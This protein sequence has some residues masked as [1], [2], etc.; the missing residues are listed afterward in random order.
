VFTSPGSGKNSRGFGLGRDPEGFGSVG[1]PRISRGYNNCVGLL[2]IGC[3]PSDEAILTVAALVRPSHHRIISC[4]LPRYMCLQT[5][6]ILCSPPFPKVIEDIVQMPYSTGGL[7][8]IKSE[9][10]IIQVTGVV[11]VVRQT[12]NSTTNN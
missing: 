2:N 3:R 1:S 10:F 8:C 11:Q 12:Q 9:F 4:T 7:C 5:T 6:Q